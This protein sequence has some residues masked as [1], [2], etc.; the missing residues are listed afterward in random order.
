[1]R[2]R[3]ASPPRRQPI[4]QSPTGQCDVVRDRFARQPAP[5]AVLGASEAASSFPL[6][7][8]HVFDEGAKVRAGHQFQGLVHLG[9]PLQA[10]EEQV[11]VLGVEG[12]Y[13]AR[14]AG[15]GA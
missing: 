4:G 10:R 9:V 1:V 5:Q 6:A 11:L 3:V 12:R 14:G 8:V 7:P 15:R 13:N 2:P